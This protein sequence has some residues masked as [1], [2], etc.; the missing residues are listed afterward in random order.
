VPGVNQPGIDA[1]FWH[2]STVNVCGAVCS[3]SLHAFMTSTG[4]YCLDLDSK[5]NV[6]VPI[7][8]I[9]MRS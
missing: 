9:L 5:G 8:G 6:F 7:T 1:D 4:Y 3:V 2:L